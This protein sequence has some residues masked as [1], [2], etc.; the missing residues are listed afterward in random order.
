MSKTDILTR[1][2]SGKQE[3]TRRLLG[4]TEALQQEITNTRKKS[5]PYAEEQRKLTQIIRE[6]EVQIQKITVNYAC[7]C[8]S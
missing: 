5:E 1:M 4:E 8:I 3:E 7:V 6:K 2:P